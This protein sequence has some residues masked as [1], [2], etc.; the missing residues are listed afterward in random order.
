[1]MEIE[2]IAR[3]LP[4]RYPFLL[5][6]RVVAVVPGGSIKG[7]K[8]LTVNEPFF[9][10]HFPGHPVM[11]GVLMI[12]ALAQLAGILAL[13]T[14]NR[15]AADGSLYYLGGVDGVRFKRPVVPGDRLDMEAQI[16]ADKRRVMKFNCR[17]WVDGE[18]ACNA[19]ITC[20]ER[21]A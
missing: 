14:K 16:L 8:N 15:S 20:V 21:S 13:R 18:V 6:D 1:M 4:H 7:Y 17:A 19:E 12:E 3:F 9:N 10:G 2:E 5:V 11:P